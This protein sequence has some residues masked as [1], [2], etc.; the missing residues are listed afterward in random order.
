MI[1]AWPGDDR[2]FIRV[3]ARGGSRRGFRSPSG[4]C[5]WYWQDAPANRLRRRL[6]HLVEPLH[7]R[8]VGAGLVPPRLR[9]LAYRVRPPGAF[10]AYP[11]PPPMNQPRRAGR[12]QSPNRRAREAGPS[13]STQTS[14]ALVF[15]EQRCE[16]IPFSAVKVPRSSCCWSNGRCSPCTPIL[17]LMRSSAH[18]EGVCPLWRGTNEPLQ[19]TE[20]WS[21]G[22]SAAH[23]YHEVQC[24][25]Y[26]VSKF[27]SGHFSEI[28]GVESVAAGFNAGEESCTT[29]PREGGMFSVATTGCAR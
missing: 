1:S 7:P 4:T 24:R 5:R 13:M 26:S 25:V 23:T 9:I 28:F 3:S 27:S 21:A 12:S 10:P 29:A 18:R 6:C 11:P 8:A 19:R 17:R 22:P 20:K 2:L 16:R 14:L 15:R